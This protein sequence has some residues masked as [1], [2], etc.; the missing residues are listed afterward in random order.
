MQES[1]HKRGNRPCFFY[2][3]VTHAID[4][5]TALIEKI[6]EQFKRIAAL[7]DRKGKTVS[8]ESVQSVEPFT[9]ETEKASVHLDE[10]VLNE[11]QATE[12]EAMIFSIPVEVPEVKEAKGRIANP[13]PQE[14]VIPPRPDFY[15]GMEEYDR[16]QEI[17]RQLVRQENAILIC[18]K[19]VEQLQQELLLCKGVFQGKRRK[20][21]QGRI[22]VKEQ[23]IA[24]TKQRLGD[25]VRGYG[26]SSVDDFMGI[27]HN[28][29]ADY[30]DYTKR[31]KE[32]ADKYG[33]KFVEQQFEE[34]EKSYMHKS[35]D[36]YS[37]KI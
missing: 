26:Y 6:R 3:I 35:K 17:Y 8:V 28:A 24:N 30:A 32:W 21:L 23:Q 14:E 16:L 1:V 13:K 31:L 33:M 22:S 5:L 10:Q 27:Y 34:R 20:E 15:M 18:E 11:P 36:I 29:K 37:I 7:L 4:V 9:E 19:E 2:S 12:P 25:I